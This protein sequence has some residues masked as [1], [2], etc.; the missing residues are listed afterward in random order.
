[1][2]F[3]NQAR[4]FKQEV[5]SLIFKLRNFDR[6]QFNCPV[7]NYSGAFK[8]VH[9]PTGT[10]KHALCPKCY[11][12][13]RHRIQYLVVDRL[14]N[15]IDTSNLSMLHFAPESFFRSYFS[16][17][18]GN[19]ET[20]D[21]YMADV[22]HQVDLQDLPFA[23]QSYD[24]IFASHVLEHISDDIKAI[25]EISRILKPN[26]MALLPV[27]L[28]AETTIEYFEPNPHEEYHVRAPGLDYFERYEPYFQK[29]EQICSNSLPSKHQLYIY[30][31]R[32]LWPTKE[33]PLRPTMYGEK[34]LDVVPVCY[35]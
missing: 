29:I 22:D 25:S 4:K 1:M 26:G 34:H 16:A 12:L 5:T 6:E 24:F 15:K 23:S 10:R 19:Y 28:V 8:D 18:F 27:P 33:C 21:L 17:K 3:K 11:A 7:C 35:V 31:D 14:L 13:E 2:N 30:E 32:S 9:P 20:A